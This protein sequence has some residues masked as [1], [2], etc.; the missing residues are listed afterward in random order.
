MALKGFLASGFQKL[1]GASRIKGANDQWLGEHNSRTI[2]ATTV[3]IP[4][5]LFPGF[6]IVNYTGTSNFNFTSG[7]SALFSVNPTTNAQVIIRNSSTNSSRMTFNSAAATGGLILAGD[8]CVLQIGDSITCYYDPVTARWREL[9]RSN[10]PQTVESRTITASGGISLL[11]VALDQVLILTAATTT[12]YALSSMVAVSGS[13]VQG[14]RITLVGATTLD[15][16]TTLTLTQATSSASNTNFKING[17]FIFTK[18]SSI[19][20]MW[21]DGGWIEISRSNLS[22]GVL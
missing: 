3:P 17:D 18:F 4:E 22:Y 6:N 10:R 20:V 11:S 5:T 19:T 12:S 8:P 21:I 1:I 15:E 16:V 2:T 13:P 9:G 14:T 7:S